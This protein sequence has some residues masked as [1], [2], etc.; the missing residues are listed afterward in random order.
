MLYEIKKPAI[1]SQYN[2]GSGTKPNVAAKG[3]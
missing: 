2:A 3:E 1:H